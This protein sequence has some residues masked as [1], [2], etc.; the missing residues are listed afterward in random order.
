MRNQHDRINLEAGPDRFW[1]L[2]GCLKFYV[3][4]LV[5]PNPKVRLGLV[6]TPAI[7]ELALETPIVAR[8][9]HFDGGSC[10]E[11]TPAHLH[12]LLLHFSPIE[13]KM[14]KCQLRACQVSDEFVRA[15]IKNRVRRTSF[16]WVAPVDGDRFHV[17]DDAVVEFCMQP[18]VQASEEEGESYWDLVVYKGNFS[19]NLFKRLVEVSTR[20]YV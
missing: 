17:T 20:R 19:K 16:P 18:D 1:T 11:L 4:F 5:T 7:A 3:P 13:L 10:A 6:F 14:S 15:L 9:L 12:K 2:S 8:E